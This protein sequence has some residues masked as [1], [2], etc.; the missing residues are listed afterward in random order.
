MRKIK[1]RGKRV[2]NGEWLYGD[3]MHDNIGGCYIYP[4]ECDN[5]YKENAVLPESVGQFTGLHDKN[6]REI[7][8]GDILRDPHSG[9]VGVV[10][11]SSMWL[12]YWLS[13]CNSPSKEGL[14]FFVELGYTVVGNIHDNPYLDID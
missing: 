2:S 8:E 5:L 10:E 6:G 13:I 1:F 4:I 12:Q 11:W 7:Y 9:E 14:P 3:L